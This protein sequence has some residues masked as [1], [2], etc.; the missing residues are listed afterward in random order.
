[1]KM[2]LYAAAALFAASLAVSGCTSNDNT[3]EP[4]PGPAALTP[5]ADG[6]GTAVFLRGRTP[7]AAS[8]RLVVEV[9][10]RGAHD[11]HGAAFR[12]TWD[13]DALT[14]VEASRGDAWS[15]NVLAMAKEG[16]PGQLAVVWTEQGEKGIDAT[17]ETILGTLTFDTRGHKATPLAF[18]LE[19]SELVDKKGVKVAAKWRGGSVPA[20]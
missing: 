18:K 8:N 13:P 3:S 15:K 7:V 4:P 19:R 6:D 5:E 16:S 2:S 20:R 12:M 17:S 11:L 14:F 9:V 10:A 1:M